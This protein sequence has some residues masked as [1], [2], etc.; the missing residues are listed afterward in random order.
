MSKL[1]LSPIYRVIR[2]L[3]TPSNNG[4]FLLGNIGSGKTTILNQYIDD[5]RG[6]N[7]PVI[8]ITL[9]ANYSL[10]LWHDYAKLYHVCLVLQ[11]MLIYIKDTNLKKYFNFFLIFN[12]KI[13]TMMTDI[14]NMYNLN[15]YQLDNSII[16]ENI[17]HNPEILLEEFLNLTM[18]HLK[19]DTLT[20][21]LDNFD[22]SKPYFVLYQK[23][24]YEM[25]KQHLNVVAT[26]S[27][28]NILEDKNKLNILSQNNTLVSIEYNYDVNTV[29]TILDNYLQE[30]GKNIISKKVSFI[31]SD[32][33]IAMLIDKTQGNIAKMKRAINIFFEH[34]KEIEYENYGTYLLNIVDNELNDNITGVVKRQ[35]KFYL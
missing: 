15:K 6:T 9:F 12:T 35:R 23:Y 30:E 31:F 13:S 11:K 34:I 28:A 16:D 33:I 8:D 17:L 4:I 19:Y 22:V 14:I 18:K 26:I 29:K 24:I 25:L 5:S 2:E 20:V 7:K 32:D 3:K 21:V 1:Y 27:D 10:A